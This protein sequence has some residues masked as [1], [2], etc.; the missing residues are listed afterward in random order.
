MSATCTHPSQPYLLNCP[1]CMFCVYVSPLH[2]SP[3][4][5]HCPHCITKPKLEKEY[6]DIMNLESL[7]CLT[8]DQHDEIY[9]AQGLESGYPEF[10]LNDPRNFNNL[11]SM[12]TTT[13]NR[14]LSKHL[15]N[16]EICLA[17]TP[18]VIN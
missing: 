7:F 8:L 18:C 6:V 9:R 16:D 17:P 4:L 11:D 10:L 13:I 14:N 3:F 12:E 1:D 15:A 5:H 2:F